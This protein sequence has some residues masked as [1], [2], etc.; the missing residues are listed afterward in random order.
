MPPS[1]DEPADV[2]HI[3]ELELSVRIGVPDAERAKPQRLT[4][5]ITMWPADSFRELGDRL[6]QTIDYAAVC[7]AVE[8]FAASRADKLIET[9]A[10][11]I[12]RHLLQSFPLRKVRLEL[13]KFILPQV[14]YVSVSLLREK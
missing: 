14:K 5:S 7:R 4:V 2:I 13:R 3:E 1:P 6:E 12:A 9:L 11:E 8:N 10:D